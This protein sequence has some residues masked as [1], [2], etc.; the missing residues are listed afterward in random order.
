MHAYHTTIVPYHV[1]PYHISLIPY[2]IPVSEYGGRSPP[3][4]AK[5]AGGVECVDGKEGVIVTRVP[6]NCVVEFRDVLEY[7]LD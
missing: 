7:D 2:Y 5:P 1:V 4:R 6:S 3:W